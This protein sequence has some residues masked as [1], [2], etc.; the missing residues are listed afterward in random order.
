MNYTQVEPPRS[1]MWLYALAGALVGFTFEL[2]ICVPLDTLTTYLFECFYSGQTCKVE[3]IPA[4]LENRKWFPGD[5]IVGIIY[6]IPLGLLYWRIKVYRLHLETLNQELQKQNRYL[7]TYMT[8]SSMVA[9]CLDPHEL[10]DAVLNVV[11][12]TVS[13]EGAAVLLLDEE[14]ANFRFYGIEG[15][16]KQCLLAVTIPADQGIAG[17]VL[18]TQ[19]SEVVNDVQRDPRYS[20]S[21]A[22]KYGLATRNL[23]AIPLTAGEEKIGVMAVLNK[24]EGEPFTEEERLLLDSIAEEIAFAIRNAKIFEYVVN[25]YCKQRQGQMSCKGCKRPLRSWTPC[26]R[27]LEKSL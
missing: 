4:I 22:S 24:V 21:F 23:I 2:V 12:E 17:S 26:V 3:N 19:R 25:S 16:A 13:A 8:V 18:Q 14:Q 15:P 6:G 10:L 1:N 5:L 20:K 9:Q 11:M 7:N 27:Y